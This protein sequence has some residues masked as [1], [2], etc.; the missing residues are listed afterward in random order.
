MPS[1]LG[2]GQADMPI[3][4][5]IWVRSNRYADHYDHLGE[6]LHPETVFHYPQI[7]LTQ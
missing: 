1:P 5:I 2:E 4:T 7:I 6:T 3:I